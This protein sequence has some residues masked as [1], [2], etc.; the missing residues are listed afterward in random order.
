MA[1]LFIGALLLLYSLA[2][3]LFQRSDEVVMDSTSGSVWQQIENFTIEARLRLEPGWRP[4]SPDGLEPESYPLGSLFFGLPWEPISPFSSP[5]GFAMNGPYGRSKVYLWRNLEWRVY[6]YEAPIVSFR[7]NPENNKQALITFQFAAH[8]YETQLIDYPENRTR[9]SIASGPWSRFSWDGRSVLIGFFEKRQRLLISTFSVNDEFSKSTLA[10]YQEVGFQ[11]MPEDIATEP[12][13]LSEDGQDLPGN[14]ALLIWSKS[15]QLWFPHYDQLWVSDGSFWTLWHLDSSGWKR[16][17]GGAGQLIPHF[18]LGFRIENPQTNTR[19]GFVH[20]DDQAPLSLRT[21]DRS[22][23][24]LPR[25]ADRWFWSSTGGI[26]YEGHRWGSALS[27]A[28]TR[29]QDELKKAFASET[30]QALVLRPELQ[31]NLREGPQVQLFEAHGKAWVWTGDQIYLLNLLET[32]TT[33]AVRAWF[34]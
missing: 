26:S 10:R 8:R 29:W 30:R 15:H 13:A 12:E 33:R 6:P 3:G 1:S 21:L 2:Q 24:E 7:L 22:L 27:I 4:I 9:W 14:R 16:S 11:K 18:P 5:H 31:V 32:P 23:D 20:I 34:R 28:P 17:Q 25:D 19:L